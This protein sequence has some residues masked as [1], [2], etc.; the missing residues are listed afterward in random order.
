MKILLKN[1]TSNS[2]ISGI[3][4][5][6][7]YPPFPLGFFAWFGFIPL[8][9]S[10]K[11][12]TGIKESFK[13]GY[14][15]GITSHFITLYWIGFNS[16]AGFIPVFLSLIGAVFYLALFWAIFSLVLYILINHKN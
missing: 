3:L 7:S 8:F 9:V 1:K 4:I 2:I 15:A 5:G 14:L 10:I 13:Y 6:M 12:C 16:G 11:N